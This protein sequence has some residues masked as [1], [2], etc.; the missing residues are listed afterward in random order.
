MRNDE[1]IQL[2]HDQ[3]C[4]VVEIHGWSPLYG[5]YVPVK[6][7]WTVFCDDKWRRL[8][9][10]L[11]PEDLPAADATWR[12]LQA[13][14]EQHHPPT[15]TV[16]KLNDYIERLHQHG[17][18]G[19]MYFNPTEAWAP[20]AE[21]MFPDDRRLGPDGKPLLV[22]HDQSAAMF[23]D[24][25]RP[26]GKYLLDQIRGE[27]ETFP[28]VDGIFFDQSAGG[29]HDLT[30]LCAE[31]CRIVRE[32]GK[33]C[34]WNGPYNMELAAL[35]DGMMTEGGGTERYR[36]LTEIIAYY[37]IAGK[38][39]ISLGPAAE[40]GYAEV[41][42][43][44][45]IPK[46][47]GA[48]NV[49]AQRWAPLFAWLKN[50]RWV[51]DAHALEVSGDIQVN[52]FRLPDGNLVAPMVCDDYLAEEV[53]PT[54][55][56]A[57]TVRVPE[58]DR[59]RAAYLLA[60]DVLG[61][62]KLDMQ[63]D[64]DALTISVPRLGRAG[65]LVLA[66]GGTFASLDGDLHVVRGADNTVRWA[67]D[68]W[69]DEPVQAGLRLQSVSGEGRTVAAGTSTQTEGELAVPADFADARIVVD[70]SASVGGAELAAAPELWVDD[71]LTVI[72]DAPAELRDDE[73][74]SVRAQ[75]LGHFDA[76]TTV[77]VEAASDFFDLAP[78]T[79]EVA[80]DPGEVA[81]VEFTG[82]AVRAGEA[83]IRV[84]STG[85]GATA[86]ATT[87][88]RVVATAIAPG[89]F[90]KIRGGGPAPGHIRRGRRAIRVQT[91]LREWDRDRRG[92]HRWRGQ[93]VVA[94]DRAPVAG[95]C[96]GAVRDERN[97]HS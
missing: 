29:G 96:R 32:Q 54:L 40:A 30:L 34:W 80:L 56:V 4:R 78:A 59:I 82:A 67:F 50:R 5:E 84:R 21:D 37:G 88:A 60:P 69:T 90:D 15:M 46:P 91:D 26:W 18:K 39:I 89:G 19:L 85:G 51:L 72:A 76:A 6:E 93:L 3:G 65:L 74:V 75:V 55:D 20:W 25:D 52:L 57:V 73:T 87:S 79:R 97:R 23:P 53:T 16:A 41:L 62:H 58:A 10:T 83:T 27:L 31:G 66:T 9:E 86:E 1:T 24:K 7:P 70:A 28:E 77:T 33:I 12:E 92:A 8:K 44:G 35:A 11:A 22:W 43:H 68:N 45:I 63:R 38:P 71:M 61:Y 47:V 94:P 2:I 36:S 81:S 14:V 42:I 95:G 17:I 64:G 13:L 49:M 48:E